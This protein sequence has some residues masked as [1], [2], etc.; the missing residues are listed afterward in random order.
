MLATEMMMIALA[1]KYELSFL[2]M[3]SM[4]CNNYSCEQLWSLMKNVKRKVGRQSPQKKLNRH[5]GTDEQN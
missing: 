3:M 2:A 1:L 4:C 5:S